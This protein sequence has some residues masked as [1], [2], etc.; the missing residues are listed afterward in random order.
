MAT[1]RTLRKVDRPAGLEGLAPLAA[2][3]DYSAAQDKLIELEQEKAAIEARLREGPAHR[4]NAI[5]DEAR[6]VLESTDSPDAMQRRQ[7]EE[8]SHRLHVLARACEIQ[9]DV[10]NQLRRQIS[11]KV[12][13]G[14][15]QT[16]IDNV[17]R[18]ICSALKDINAAVQR[19]RDFKAHVGALG[20]EPV[21]LPLDPDGHF[22]ELVRK[23]YPIIELAKTLEIE[24][25]D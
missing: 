25:E 6:A 10:V 8:D 1:P 11:A 18:P 19:H 4:P 22:N 5:E 16:Q 24:I 9:A 17:I 7:Y 3:E 21:Y 12:L 15:R 14:F 13:A 23:F 2:R 20:Y